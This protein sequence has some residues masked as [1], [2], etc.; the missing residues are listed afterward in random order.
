MSRYRQRNSSDRWGDWKQFFRDPLSWVWISAFLLHLVALL[1]IQDI[2]LFR[3]T[4]SPE[5]GVFF[6][7]SMRFPE[8]SPP[9]DPPAT[10]QEVSVKID[11]LAASLN[12]PSSGE[13]KPPV[14]VTPQEDSMRWN[15]FTQMGSASDS[16]LNSGDLSKKGILTPGARIW[17][18]QSPAKKVVFLIDISGTMW[19]EIDGVWGFKI[20]QAEVERSISVMPPDMEF[21]VIYYSDTVSLLSPSL[22]PASADNK[23]RARKFLSS[24]PAMNGATDFF[25]GLRSGFEQRPE[26]IFLFTDGEMDIPKWKVPS[27]LDE[28]RE[29]YRSKTV[30]FG[31]GFFYQKN[32]DS[33]DLLQR[34]CFLSGG[35]FKKYP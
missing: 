18:L 9:V 5:H 24:V 35:D 12:P 15:P 19:N 33:L 32:Q 25:K 16:K 20:A 3:Q 28:L 4:D 2:V 7:Q 13:K 30:L 31:I 8:H 11:P 27:R 23:E 10:S 26:A 6:M 21:N 14:P 29:T 17:N 34:L 1:W 22:L